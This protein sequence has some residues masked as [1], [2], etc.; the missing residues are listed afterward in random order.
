V[1]GPACGWE[2]PRLH[3]RHQ[4]HLLFGEVILGEFLD[5]FNAGEQARQNR[6]E[7]EQRKNTSAQQKVRDAITA[8]NKWVSDVLAP[9]VVELHNDLAS[10]GNVAIAD[11]GRPPIVA[12]DVTIALAGRKPTQLSFQVRDD[13][14]INVYRDGSQANTIGAIT[15]I[16][17]V[18][19]KDIFRQTIKSIGEA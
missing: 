1:T 17:Q 6:I 9:V 11:T 5:A 13:G 3:G 2:A 4:S 19:I 14:A 15:T 10:V 18:Q 7:E 8:A 12:R 16:S